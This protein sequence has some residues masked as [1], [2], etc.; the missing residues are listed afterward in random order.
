MPTHLAVFSASWQAA[1][2]V[3]AALSHVYEEPTQR[4]ISSAHCCLHAAPCDVL[5]VKLLPEAH[6]PSNINSKSASRVIPAKRVRCQ[7]GVSKAISCAVCM[8]L[9]GSGRGAV[10]GHSLGCAY[11][12]AQLYAYPKT[13]SLISFG[14]ESLLIEHK[15]TYRRR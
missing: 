14:C 12:A 11:C 7:R 15:R 1:I 9:V 6:P 3:D 5:G 13:S 4:P 8:V 10:C 2:Q